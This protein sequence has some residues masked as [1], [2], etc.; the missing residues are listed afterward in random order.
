MDTIPVALFPDAMPCTSSLPRTLR[1]CFG[2]L[3]GAVGGP[4]A[5]AET[6]EATVAARRA[7][8]VERLTAPDS[9]LTLVGLHPLPPGTHTLGSAADNA[10]RLA[11]G[12]AHLGVITRNVAG[13][14]HL[15]LAA[16]AAAEIVGTDG[17]RAP[18]SYDEAAPTLV[19][20]GGFSFHVIGRSGEL[21]LRARS[22]D[23]PTRTHFTGLDYF[24]LDPA[25]RIEARWE[26]F[27][28]PRL[29]PITNKLGQT[30]PTPAQGKAVFTHAGR[31]IELLSIDDGDGAL[32]FV[33]SDETSGDETYG[34]CRFVDADPPRD[35]KV[36]LD[37]NL[38]R[39]PPCAFTPFA[40]CPLPPKEN[41][42]PF[43]VAAGEKNYRGGSH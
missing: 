26:P 34:A 39:N 22:A 15:E 12:P 35:G 13:G 28:Q 16:E 11:G 10:I 29:V 42:L 38:A 33:I 18:L 4:V 23:A 14:V 9:W 30:A 36:I 3:S 19:R 25:W 2:L 43:R 32:F 37:F 5:T 31:T 1:I 20:S 40:T 24:P 17:R 27:D 6:Y 21:F 7:A 8:R 41:R